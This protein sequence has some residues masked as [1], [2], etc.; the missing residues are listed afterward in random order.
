MLLWF[1]LPSDVVQRAAFSVNSKNTKALLR[2]TSSEAAD[3]AHC[4]RAMKNTT[5]CE[6]G[7]KKRLMI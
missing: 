3:A 4:A 5:K 6:W 2:G 1:N 7:R